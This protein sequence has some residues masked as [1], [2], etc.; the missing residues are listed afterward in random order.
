MFCQKG[1]KT[2]VRYFTLCMTQSDEFQA[3]LISSNQFLRN[4]TAY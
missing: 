1:D 4:L 3:P 2:V